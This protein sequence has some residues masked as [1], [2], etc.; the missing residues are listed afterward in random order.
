MSNASAVLRRHKPEKALTLH[1]VR[2]PTSP[3]QLRNILRT[4]ELRVLAA[5]VGFYAFTFRVDPDELGIVLRFGKIGRQEPPGLHFRLPYP[6][7]EVRLPKVT[8]QNII[9]IGMQ[10]EQTGAARYATCPKRAAC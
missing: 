5:L 4:W 8:R 3:V 1:R 9:Q 6:V 2:M 7:D 10:W